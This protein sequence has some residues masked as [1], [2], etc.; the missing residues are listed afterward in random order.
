MI[1]PLL[2]TALL[3]AGSPP[4]LLSAQA[5][6]AQAPRA[7]E[8]GFLVL[9]KDRGFLGNEALR[10]AFEAFAAGRNA[11][12]AFV[13]DARTGATLDAALRRLA[14]AGAR[15][16]VVLPCFLSGAD[17]ALALAK[18]LLAKRPE[19]LQWARPF[20][21]SAL[22]VEALADRLR[23]V[24]DGA[25]RRLVL[26]GEAPEG[27]E[28]RAAHAADLARI[29]AWASEGLGFE[30]VKVVVEGEAGL[31]KA[32]EAAA[33]GAE[34][35]LIVPFHL[36][37]KLDGMMGFEPM[38]RGAAPHGA[39]LRPEDP[40]GHPALAQW[41]GREAQRRLAPAPGEVGVVLLAHG[42]D[43]HWNETMVAAVESLKGRYLLEPALCMADPPVVA[44]AVK[45][46]EQRGAKTIVIVRVFGM[47]ASFR[48]DVERMIGFDVERGGLPKAQ[49]GGGHH[50][51]HGPAQ[52]AP[53]LRS[54]VDLRTAGGLEDHPLFA[55]ALLDRAQAL[56]KDPAKETLFLVAH[57]SGDDRLNAH[58]ESILASL[59]ARM[60]ANGAPF[61]AI[62]TGTWRED[63]PEQRKPAL[64]KL[65]AEIREAGLKGG[66]A[67]VV[68][69]RTLGQGFERT[70]L[71]GL[72]YELGEG[73]APH[74]LFAAWFEEQVRAGLGRPEGPSAPV[75]G[76]P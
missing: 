37:K 57:G 69:A 38:V 48:A 8:T 68:P 41:M 3:A 13:T 74:P 39:D 28:A 42:S 56:S 34:Q 6:T 44:R 12:L 36:G 75:A 17:P 35:P 65:R 64:A 47:E 16:T 43:H 73:F 14:Q 9:A 63:W 11:T 18:G 19:A 10:D 22:A 45:R 25:G 54:A 2:L 58:W 52:P 33:E 31:A 4:L 7:A 59:A 27:S 51:H 24:P 40:A 49:G 50:G 72:N 62:R 32:L 67:L 29:G 66:R 20:G 46:L 30:S 70:F 53:R 21:E 26:V 60:K 1:R 61:K 23:A 71:D 5:A 76:Q 55:Q 15:R